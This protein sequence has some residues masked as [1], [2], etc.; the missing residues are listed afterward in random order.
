MSL[1]QFGFG[2]AVFAV[3]RLWFQAQTP[4]EKSRGFGLD[5]VLRVVFVGG[6]G[7]TDTSYFFGG[8]PHQNADLGHACGLALMPALSKRRQALVLHFFV[9]GC[10][11]AAAGM[12]G[13]TCSPA[14]WWIGGFVAPGVAHPFGAAFGIGPV[15]PTR[16][17]LRRNTGFRFLACLGLCGVVWGIGFWLFYL[18]SFTG[19]AVFWHPVLRR[20]WCSF[21]GAQGETPLAHGLFRVVRRFG[22]GRGG[23]RRLLRKSV[24]PVV[25]AVDYASCP[26]H[27][28]GHKHTSTIPPFPPPKTAITSGFT[29]SL[30]KCVKSGTAAVCFRFDS[31]TKKATCSAPR[32]SVTWL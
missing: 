15:H 31:L 5:R 17:L 14:R 13:T 4:V 24:L 20:L 3:T 29:C 16:F 11:V 9:A 21:G 6:L 30:T 27:G 10:V 23:L 2:I 32:S 1:A 12:V 19:G 8:H 28:V 7:S 18:K 25:D 26:T 22:V